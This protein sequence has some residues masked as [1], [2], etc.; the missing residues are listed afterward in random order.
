LAYFLADA[1]TVRVSIPKESLWAA[2]YEWCEEHDLIVNTNQTYFG[3]DLFQALP[4]LVSCRPREGVRRVTA[5]Y[6]VALR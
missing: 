2:Y 3:R 5:Y 4:G 6:G 1:D